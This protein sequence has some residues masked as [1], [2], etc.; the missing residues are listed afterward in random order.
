MRIALIHY[1]LQRGGVTT[2]IRHQAEAIRAMGW[3]P[4]VLSGEP[5]PASFP[6][7]VEIVGG[8]AYDRHLT[9]EHSPGRTVGAIRQTLA[10]VWPQGAD[11]VHVHNPTLAKNRHLQKILWD[12]QAH[13]STILCQ[14]HDFA[15]DGRPDAFFAEPYL[16]DCHYIA[17]NPRD[18][19]LLREAGLRPE[20]C[21]LLPNTLPVRQSGEEAT[22]SPPF[23][24]FYPIR[25]IRRKN[26]GEAI[27]IALFLPPAEPLHITLP[28][29][30]PDD[31]KSYER[32][33]AFVDR[34]GLP[35]HFDAGVDTD[36]DAL[37]A[38]CRF[39]VTTSI[40]EGFGFA[41]LEAWSEGKPLWGRL[42]PDICRGF[43][44]NGMQLD[45]FYRHLRA[46]LA[47]ID[48]NRLAEKWKRA[49]SGAGR[50]FD[51]AM[52]DAR[53][54][55][56]WESVVSDGL[57]D[58]GL[59]DESC[60]EEIIHRILEI[61]TAR[62]E[63]MGVNPFLRRPGPPERAEEVIAANRRVIDRHYRPDAYARRLRKIYLAA[64]ASPVRHRLD[65]AVLA[66]EFLAAK[67]FSLLKWGSV[68]E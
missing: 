59:L 63:L 7:R 38:G 65:K 1:H 22:S 28:P 50:R 15:E 45:W 17:I 39:V 29:N 49:M 31:R 61:P 3:T 37:L 54:A 43:M 32:W 16:A 34:H 33:K 30:S 48:G 66:R 27:L 8:L 19:G 12:L 21:H 4:L 64:S 25:A 44:D 2:V 23:G 42:L 52:T 62:E 46:P 6:C 26:I 36:F 55:S 51:I 40:T 56:A 57:I 9:A 67:R 24:M 41:Y 60:Q 14:I 11:L 53:I 5:A 58:F 10:R 18:H 13:G 47:W 20:G 68:D 35:V